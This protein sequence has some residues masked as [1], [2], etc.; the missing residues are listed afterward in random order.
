MARRATKIK[1]VRGSAQNVLLLDAGNALYAAQGVNKTTQ[2]KYMVEAMNRLGYDAMLLGDQDFA[3]GVDV[4][5]Q[6]IAEARFPVLS[7]NVFVGGTQQLLAQPY[8]LKDFSGQT[9]AII[10]IT[11]RALSAVAPASGSQPLVVSD[12]VEALKKVMADL[13]GKAN[14]FVVL[15]NLGFAEDNS[16]A[17]AVPG[18]TAIVGGRSSTLLQEPWKDPASGTLVVQAGFQGEWIGEL[19]IRFDASGKTTSYKGTSVVLS[20]VF[21]DDPEVRAWLDSLPK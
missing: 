10:G 5:K 9:I 7:A 14:I 13:K 19:E 4:L 11:S 18:I 15:S 3:W 21:P 17:S 8:I 1:Q 20:E 2:G 12:P 16:L 6:R